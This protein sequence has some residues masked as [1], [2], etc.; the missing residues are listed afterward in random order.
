MSVITT[1]V[2]DCQ[3]CHRC[4]RHCPVKAIS[5]RLGQA[6]IIDERCIA[7][8]CCT[9]VCPQQAK[10]IHSDLLRAKDF[11]AE[12]RKVALSV[13]PS[14]PAAFPRQV[15]DSFGSMVRALGFSW[16][17]ETAVGAQVVARE[18]KEL[19]EGRKEPLIS[20]CCPAVVN[21]IEKHY[22]ALIPYLAPSFS[23]MATHGLMLKKRYG[24]DTK[25]VF[26]GPC[27]AKIDEV[28]RREVAGIVDAVITFPELEKWFEEAAIAPM[29]VSNH[30]RLYGGGSL[31]A[32]SFP[33]EGGVL[34]AA[35]IARDLGSRVLAV[36]GLDECLATFDDLAAGS[37]NPR[38]I[39]AMVCSGGCVGGPAMPQGTSAA[40]NRL[41]VEAYFDRANK[42]K[43]SCELPE[44]MFRGL[45]LTRSFHDRRQ[46]LPEPTPEDIAA[47]L[48]RTGK[49][50]P[51][52]EA[53]CGGCGYDSCREKAYA[54]YQGWAEEEMC[55]PYMKSKISSLAVAIVNSTSSAVI[56]T[57]SNLIVQ[58]VN[59]RALELFALD[60]DAVTGQPLGNFFDPNNFAMAWE[61]QETI[62]DKRVVYPDRERVTLQTILPIKDYS[63]IVGII[64]DISN[65]ERD[66]EEARQMKQEALVR[67][68]QVITRQMKAAQEIASLMGETTAETKATLHQLIELARG[69]EDVGNAIGS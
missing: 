43:T 10:V 6:H 33:V 47:I 3:D 31:S 44:E 30:N 32:R 55:I 67:A 62:V 13:A 49:T 1:R 22:P 65:L 69:K 61:E 39:E 52:D 21:L 29:T 66:K 5:F 19:L 41:K 23:P 11:L 15:V 53:N 17:E 14:F 57:D 38:F 58:E 35:G 7:C 42:G 28:R 18:Y 36:N 24:S 60:A 26:V 64:N 12:G 40:A 48:A 56:V 37:I 20:A 2:A 16:V 63:L 68:E 4:L 34:Q 54:V 51:A 9:L 50:R 45:Q 25:V 8:G 27:I 59:P 46:K